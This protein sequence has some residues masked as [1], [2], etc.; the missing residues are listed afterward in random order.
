[1]RSFESILG[2]LDRFKKQMNI[3][4]ALLDL[5]SFSIAK[6]GFGPG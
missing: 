5:Q 2:M 1:M 6:A 4:V 3:S